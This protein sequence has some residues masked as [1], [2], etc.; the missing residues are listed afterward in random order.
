MVVLGVILGIALSIVFEAGIKTIIKQVRDLHISIT[1]LNNTQDKISQ[2]LDS[3]QGKLKDNKA[4]VPA[5]KP[6]PKL[7]GATSIPVVKKDT[8]TNKKEENDSNTDD[9]DVADKNSDSNIVVMTNQL[10]SVKNVPLSTMD[11][12]TKE[13]S[14][15]HK[16]DSTIAAM[17]NVSDEQDPRYYRI[18]F[19]QSP[20]N[21]KGYKM[22]R[23]KIILYGINSNTDMRLVKWSDG[24][25][26]M[27][28]QAVYKM[29]YTDDYKPFEKVM[30]KTVLKRITL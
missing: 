28:N 8:I 1:R 24:Y 23:G 19:W 10:V 18:E 15:N 16:S 14:I 7:V 13:A 17:S 21:F 29:E 9:A 27:S 25:Y 5:N 30:D 20:L 4:T 3:I 26:L 12:L 22:S 2:R 11:S 6:M